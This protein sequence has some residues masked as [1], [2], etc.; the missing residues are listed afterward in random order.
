[1]PTRALKPDVS[2]PHR[3]TGRAVGRQTQ[4]NAGQYLVPFPS[5]VFR[6]TKLLLSRKLE[7]LPSILNGVEWN[8]VFSLLA[9][10]DLAS[11]G[12]WHIQIPLIDL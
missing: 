6:I 9:S 5:I 3:V 10:V 1:M 2:S 7:C 11:Q 4:R 8:R 12:I